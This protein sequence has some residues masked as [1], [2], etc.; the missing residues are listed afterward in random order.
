MHQYEPS[1]LR[2]ELYEGLQSWRGHWPQLAAEAG[3][4]YSWICKAVRPERALQ[5]DAVESVINVLRD[6]ATLEN[7]DA[8]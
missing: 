7:D 3:I 4:S 8:A 6:W 1:N 5:L 2:A